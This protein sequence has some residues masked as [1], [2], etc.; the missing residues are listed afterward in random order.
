MTIA[1]H[2]AASVGHGARAIEDRATRQAIAD[3]RECR[4]RLPPA[5]PAQLD[6]AD[7]LGELCGD[8]ARTFGVAGR[9]R[10]GC[11]VSDGLLPI[12]TAVRLGLIADK[13]IENAVRHG[14]PAGRGGRIAV[15]FSATPDAWLLMV[16]D[17][18]VGLPQGTT[19]GA[20]L[21]T[22]MALTTRL[23]GELVLADVIAGNRCT[24]TLPR[25][26]PPAGPMP[27]G[28][29]PSGPEK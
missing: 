2:E 8:F 1:L 15:A 16:E 21:K 12:T 13:L 9:V 14:F 29:D 28:R 17:S 22:A 4:R 5:E 3:A 10:L 27:A 6:L 18:G 26:G 19:A 24:V 11:A 23:G 7:H 20:G 25:R